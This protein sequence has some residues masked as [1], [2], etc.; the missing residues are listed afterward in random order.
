MET[1]RTF[2]VCYDKQPLDL[3]TLP[4][5]LVLSLP[6]DYYRNYERELFANGLIIEAEWNGRDEK[7]EYMKRA[8]RTISGAL[9]IMIYRRNEHNVFIIDY[10]GAYDTHTEAK[11]PQQNYKSFI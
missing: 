2:K 3:A 6:D 9:K 11:Y 4:K 1:Y 5:E 7:G 8:A 10:I